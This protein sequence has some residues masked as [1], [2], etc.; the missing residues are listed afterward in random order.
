MHKIVV[1]LSG[2]KKIRSLLKVYWMVGAKHVFA[3]KSTTMALLPACSAFVKK[4]DIWC[5]Y[6]AVKQTSVIFF[7]SVTPLTCVSS[8]PNFVFWGY[9]LGLYLKVTLYTSIW[10][11]KSD[12]VFQLSVPNE[13]NPFD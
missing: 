10:C 5:Y 4:R 6:S 11:L 9:E 1:L 2:I 7:P 3:S 13:N 12:T 8:L